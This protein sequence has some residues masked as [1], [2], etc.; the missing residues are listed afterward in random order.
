[1]RILYAEDEKDLNE[2]VTKTLQDEHYMVDS[3]FD[4]QEAIDCLSCAEYD[5]VIL[6]VMMPIKDGYD[7]LKVI[8]E[9]SPGTPV[10]FL[11]AKDAVEERVRGLD[12][13]ANDYLVK[14]FSL[15][16][17]VARVRVMTRLYHNAPSSVLKVADLE[18]DTSSHRVKRAGVEIELTAKEYQLLE[19]LAY[20]QGKVL[21]RTKIEDHIWDFDY[22]GGTNVVDVYI[23]YLRQKIDEGH[24]LKL[25]RT[26]RGAGYLITGE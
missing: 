10:L 13:G 8:K 15:E 21:S 16:E 22:E 23:R 5:A 4:G 2:V 18:I 3:C 25:I 14:P 6:D 1:M 19:Y 7:V 17:L 12:A 20:N 11:T 9:Q 24:E 26:K